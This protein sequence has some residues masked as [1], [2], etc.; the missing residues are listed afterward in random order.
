LLATGG[1]TADRHVRFWNTHTGVMLSQID[2]ESQ[3]VFPKDSFFNGADDATGFLVCP[4]FP[5]AACLDGKG[6]KR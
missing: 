5:W 6:L 1:G 4:D 2:T 3:V